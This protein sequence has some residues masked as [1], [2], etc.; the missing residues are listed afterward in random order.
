MKKLMRYY[1]D[2]YVEGLSFQIVEQS[3]TVTN[4]VKRVGVYEASNGWRITI[5]KEPEVNVKDRV[6]FLQGKKKHKN[7][8]ICRVQYMSSDKEAKKTVAAIDRAIEDLCNDALNQRGRRPFQ[9]IDEIIID[10]RAFD[11]YNA[12]FGYD[13]RIIIIRP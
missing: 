5:D 10:T 12:A 2:P 9:I 1:C 8:K 13:P 11:C 4:Y 3:D 7:G 6:I